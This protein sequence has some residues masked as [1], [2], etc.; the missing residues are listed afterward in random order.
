[1]VTK[2][3]NSTIDTQR[4]KEKNPFTINNQTTRKLKKK[5]KKRTKIIQNN[6]QIT[7]RITMLSILALNLNR[8][9]NQIK[10]HR[11]AEW[12]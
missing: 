4:K 10:W 1:M 9:N 2:I 8:I 7:N 6:P 12:I 3:Q 5:E 11:V